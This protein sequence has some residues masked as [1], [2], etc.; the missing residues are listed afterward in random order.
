M[1]EKIRML[2]AF[3]PQGY[4][5]QGKIDNPTRRAKHSPQSREQQ[6]PKAW[7]NKGVCQVRYTD[8]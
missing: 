8:E 6:K 4:S 7:V 3:V 2:P 1:T 5:G